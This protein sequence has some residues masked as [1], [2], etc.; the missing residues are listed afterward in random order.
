MKVL[1]QQFV[2]RF[3]FERNFAS[4]ELVQH[5]DERVD[6]ALISN[7]VAHRQFGGHVNWRA[8]ARARCRDA[9][10]SNNLCYT[11]VGQNGPYAISNQN[12]GRF[13]VSMNNAMLMGE[14]NC[15]CQLCEQL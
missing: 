2:N 6:I 14:A 11:K 8:E 3:A 5:Y 4:D 9:C 7:R 1:R 13:N 12:V 15:L 10:Q